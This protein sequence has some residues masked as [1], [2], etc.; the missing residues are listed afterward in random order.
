MFRRWCAGCEGG[1][2]GWHLQVGRSPTEM[3]PDG[4]ADSELDSPGVIAARGLVPPVR[5]HWSD[6]G[7]RPPPLPDCGDR[8]LASEG[9]LSVGERGWVLSNW[10]GVKLGLSPSSRQATVSRE[11][12]RDAPGPGPTGK[13]RAAGATRPD[14]ISSGPGLSRRQCCW[15]MPPSARANLSIGT[16]RAA[17]S[18]TRPKQT[19]ICGKGTRTAG[20]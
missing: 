12:L 1:R 14:A 19:N 8:A 7:L 4:S 17:N 9:T 5:V 6:G 15:A 13:R 16:G 3:G 10:D 2:L 18:L 11:L 20:R